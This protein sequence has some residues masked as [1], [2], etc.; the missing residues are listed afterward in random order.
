MCVA[1]GVA[2][3]DIEDA[4]RRRADLDGEP[5]RRVRLVD[6]ER[7]RAREERL[8]AGSRAGEAVGSEA[9]R[10]SGGEAGIWTPTGT[11]PWAG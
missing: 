9:G 2:G 5:G 4:E 1:A 3:E 7:Q 6:R 11:C 10:G 8:D